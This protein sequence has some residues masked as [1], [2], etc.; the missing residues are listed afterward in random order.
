MSSVIQCFLGRCLVVQT[1]A[2]EWV[3]DSPS[4]NEKKP[5]QRTGEPPFVTASPSILFDGAH[6]GRA[7][8]GWLRDG[9]LV[10]C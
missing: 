2:G 10:E 1:P 9:Q 8:H 5:W 6:G 7:Y 3:V 4:A